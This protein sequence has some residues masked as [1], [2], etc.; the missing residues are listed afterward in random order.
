MRFMGAKAARWTDEVHQ[1]AG[2]W[3]VYTG[4]VHALLLH[5]D[6][7]PM[8]W[9]QVLLPSFTGHQGLPVALGIYG[10]YAFTAVTVSGYLLGAIKGYLWRW[11]HWL[12]FPAWA[13]ALLHA[14]ML[15]EHMQ[16]WA[17][18]MYGASAVVILGLSAVRFLPDKAGGRAPTEERPELAQ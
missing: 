10:L 1:W 2:A 18:V 7:R 9:A 14:L 17:Q 15:G 11:I 3:T 8:G 6:V 13:L 12:A 5:Y 16:L 4:L